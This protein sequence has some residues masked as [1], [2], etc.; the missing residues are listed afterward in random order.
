MRFKITFAA[1]AIVLCALSGCTQKDP[2]GITA[3]APDYPGNRPAINKA[4]LKVNEDYTVGYT[5]GSIR[6]EQ[7]TLNWTAVNV[8]DFLCYKLYRDGDPA[9][10][11]TWTSSSTITYT[12]MD[13]SYLNP[14]TFYDYKIAALNTSGMYTTDT[15]Q[16]KTLLFDPPGWSDA[17]DPVVLDSTTTPYNRS[18][19]LSW[20]DNAEYSTGFEIERSVDAANYV[21]LTTVPGTTY[22][23]ASM[24]ADS[25]STFYYRV[26]AITPYEQ[27]DPSFVRTVPMR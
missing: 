7:V 5:N 1:A 9:P 19:V 23:D 27:T 2:A 20:I 4:R 12:D 10:I 15:V 17:N 24:G 21:M 16:V 25:T 18:V 22:T 3:F 14:D 26:R 8:A 6:S 11:K 13:T